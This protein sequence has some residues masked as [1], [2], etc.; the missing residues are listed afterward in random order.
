MTLGSQAH[1]GR[2]VIDRDYW[3]A[4]VA[5]AMTYLTMSVDM[6]SERTVGVSNK[7]GA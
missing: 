2:T 6:T 1:G 5:L 7:F 4:Q 3:Q